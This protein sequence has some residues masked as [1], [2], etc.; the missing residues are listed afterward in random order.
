[1][2]RKQV[3][4]IGSSDETAFTDEARA[5]GGFIAGKGCVLITGGR[6]GIMEAASQGAAERGGIV[7]GILPGEGL[8]AANRF[9]TM[10]I[11]TGMGYARN[12]IN[13]L[14]ADLVV[15]IGGKSGTLS[16]LAYARIYGKPVVCCTFAGGWSAEFP[17][18]GVDDYPGGRL[19]TARDVDEACRHIEYLL[20]STE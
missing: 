7:V 8:D 17:N 5:I 11:P 1:V 20:E 2:R 10:V 15:A 14:S 13:I 3:V 4:V 6:G 19:M 16:E 18:A 12:V 9:C